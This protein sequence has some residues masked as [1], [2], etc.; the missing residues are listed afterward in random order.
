MF[1]ENLL[2]KEVAP[3]RL[4]SVSGLDHNTTPI[5]IRERFAVSHERCESVLKD[6][7]QHPGVSEAVLLSTCN[8]TEI[9]STGTFGESSQ[10]AEYLTNVFEQISGVQRDEFNDR[11]YHFTGLQAVDHLFRVAA[12]LNSMILGEPQVLGQ[13]KSAYQVASAC[14]ATSGIINRLFERAFSVAKT[15]RTETQIGHNAVSVCYAAKELAT[16]IFGDLSEATVMM[17]GAGET[18]VLALKHFK[19]AGSEKIFVANKTVSKAGVVADHFGAVALE[20]NQVKNFIHEIDIIVGASE[21]PRDSQP[22]VE[23]EIVEVCMKQRR[24][25]PQFFIDLGVPRNFECSINELPDVFLYNIDDL[26]SV[27]NQNLGA[28]AM[29]VKRAEVI[30]D[31]Q[32]KRFASWLEKREVEPS[33]RQA[34]MRLENYR[35]YELA[36]TIRR[37]KRNG[38]SEQQCEELIPVLEDFSA[39]LVAKIMHR[40]LTRVMGMFPGN[41]SA[42]EFF[43]EFFVSGGKDEDS[44]GTD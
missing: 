9:V 16:Q 3:G 12:G 37:L 40:P 22:L 39:G 25:R 35:N 15:V 2:P 32:V 42:L 36:K 7:T 1:T 29:E 26:E 27:V 24:G 43:R 19:S 44:T 6:I 31:E 11:M 14:G 5:E 10:H 21:L 8:R 34:R 33:I 18:G 28:R 41:H 17:L 20:L 30:V 4:I 13:L 23:S 38:F